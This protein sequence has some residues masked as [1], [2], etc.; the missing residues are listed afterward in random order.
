MQIVITNK[1][2][3]ALA[4]INK[5]QD[6]KPFGYNETYKFKF[7]SLNNCDLIKSILYVDQNNNYFLEIRR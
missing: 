5:A 2:L 1:Q 4:I 6:V 7:I 3:L